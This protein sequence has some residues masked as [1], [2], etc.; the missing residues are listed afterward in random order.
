MD[1][2]ALVSANDMT[3]IQGND[4]FLTSRN[5]NHSI[6]LLLNPEADISALAQKINDRAAEVDKYQGDRLILRP[7]NDIYFANHLQYEKNTK[8]G[9]IQLVIV[10]SI[11]ALLI[12]G[13]ACINFIN[14]TIAKTKTREKEWHFVILSRDCLMIDGSSSRDRGIKRTLTLK[15]K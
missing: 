4:D 11:I 1:I 9:N 5:Y 12:L 8:H 15:W 10:F 7:F 13:I 3:R 14:L 6:Y 2:N